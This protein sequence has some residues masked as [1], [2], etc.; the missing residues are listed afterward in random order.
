MGRK[1]GAPH[2]AKVRDLKRPEDGVPGG[3]PA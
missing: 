2:A 1:P 3:R